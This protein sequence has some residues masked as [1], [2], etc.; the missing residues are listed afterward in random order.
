MLR[1]KLYSRYF[2]FLNTFKSFMLSISKYAKQ[3]FLV[4]ILL[5]SI[6]L[7]ASAQQKGQK[8]SFKNLSRPEKWWVVFHP[9]VVKKSFTITQNTLELTDSMKYTGTLDPNSSGGQLDAYKHMMWMA[10]LTQEIGWRKSKSLG[11]AHE[12]GNYTT[13]KKRMKKKIP[14]THDHVASE[15][16]LWNNEVGIRIGLENPEAS[17]NEIEEKV[18]ESI[19]SGEGRVIKRDAKGNFLDC[20][21]NIIPSD[22]LE[23]KWE[24]DKCLVPSDFRPG[25]N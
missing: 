19:L 4:S 25:K 18:V 13:F 11:I 24:T 15:M 10:L 23:G 7:S 17:I 22:S 1:F 9:F 21:N 20:K 16:D 6:C 5:L 3:A 12:K 8:A 2:I 14:T